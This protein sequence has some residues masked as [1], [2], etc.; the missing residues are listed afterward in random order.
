MPD[1]THFHGH[2]V[3]GRGASTRQGKVCARDTGQIHTV[4]R[5][6]PNRKSE[7]TYRE[8]CFL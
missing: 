7:Q 6:I 3:D 2:P 8:R 5:G 1:A 4:R